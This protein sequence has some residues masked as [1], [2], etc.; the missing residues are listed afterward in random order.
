MKIASNLQE[1]AKANEK[2]PIP[3]RLRRRYVC[4]KCSA[5]TEGAFPGPVCPSCQGLNSVVRDR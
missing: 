4:L 3:V 1:A 2:K 5:R